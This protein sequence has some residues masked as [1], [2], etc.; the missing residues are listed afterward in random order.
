MYS[1]RERNNVGVSASF[2]PGAQASPQTSPLT[3]PEAAVGAHQ[4]HDNAAGQGPRDR[5]HRGERP[6]HTQGHLPPQP[7][8]TRTLRCH[9]AACGA[10]LGLCPQ[11]LHSPVPNRPTPR[12]RAAAQRDRGLDQ[13]HLAGQARSWPGPA[14]SPQ[15][16][17]HRDQKSGIAVRNRRSW[18]R[19]PRAPPPPPPAPAE[20]RA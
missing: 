3:G 5:R 4:A 13:G 6:F 16:S 15:T 10:A 17:R 20:K 11:P 18:S 8:A 2:S 14:L 9:G 1:G 12:T 7:P 19:K